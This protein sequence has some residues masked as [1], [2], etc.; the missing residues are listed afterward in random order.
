[1]ASCSSN[2]EGWLVRV[3][4][5][6]LQVFRELGL[7]A[8]KQAV[9]TG[10]LGIQDQPDLRETM[11]QNKWAEQMAQQLRA[12][13][14]SVDGRGSVPS[15]LMATAHSICNS[16]SRKSDTLCWLR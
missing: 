12:F 1:M 6:S 9:E 5:S 2:T 14:A 16:S 13:S 15:T 4:M 11:S 8:H 7:G 10:G 3:L